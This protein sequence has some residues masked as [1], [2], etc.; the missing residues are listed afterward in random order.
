MK[1]KE[2]WDFENLF[3]DRGGLFCIGRGFGVD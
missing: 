2:V 3:L 1:K